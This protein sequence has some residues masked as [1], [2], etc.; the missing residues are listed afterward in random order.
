MRCK[1]AQNGYNGL[2]IDIRVTKVTSA[3]N[4]NLFSQ[5]KACTI[6][7]ISKPVSNTNYILYSSYASTCPPKYAFDGDTTYTNGWICNADNVKTCSEYIGYYFTSKA[8]VTKVEYVS[9]NGGSYWL[10]DTFIIQY[11]DDGVNWYNASNTLTA[12]KASSVNTVNISHNT[13]HHYW[14][15]FISGYM[16]GS[17]GA[18]GLAELQFYGYFE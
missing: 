8:Y 1:N 14:R 3:T 7:L 15:Y 11:S 6:A 16:A 9:C 10:A 5:W 4:K 17:G 18:T 13:A 2:K 12:V